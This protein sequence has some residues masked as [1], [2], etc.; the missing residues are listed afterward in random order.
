MERENKPHS[1]TS[2]TSASYVKSKIAEKVKSIKEEASDLDSSLEIVSFEENDTTSSSKVDTEIPKD[3]PAEMSAGILMEDED[4]ESNETISEE[5]NTPISDIPAEISAGILVDN[6]TETV[7][8]VVEEK[9]E[10]LEEIMAIETVSKEET[11]LEMVAEVEKDVEESNDFSHEITEDDAT[12]LMNIGSK[13]ITPIEE[14]QKSE[15]SSS[16]IVFDESTGSYTDN[17]PIAEKLKK[18]LAK[19]HETEKAASE[20]F[21]SPIE[22][23][24]ENTSSNVVIDNGGR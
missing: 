16:S 17:L 7:E 2:N 14:E 12:T 20:V 6:V 15:E 23:E 19:L 3:I 24:E 11:V 18:T 22:T 9:Q 8:E 1:D 5:P 13:E 21:K 10:E 4:N